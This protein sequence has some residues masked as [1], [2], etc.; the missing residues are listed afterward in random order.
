M[1]ETSDKNYYRSIR[2]QYDFRACNLM[3]IIWSTGISINSILIAI[4]AILPSISNYKIRTI[5]ALLCLSLI[6]VFLL[7]RNF[8]LYKNANFKA[9][10][11]FDDILKMY[12][13]ADPIRT[14][15]ESHA[16]TRSEFVPVLA[17]T[18]RAEYL[19]VTIFLCQILVLVFSL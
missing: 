13:G 3:P 5:Y 15:N 6:S 19:V 16:K 9:A 17:A 14:Q 2:D 7:I 18:R 8:I 12:N 10:E 1:N 11:I 4:F